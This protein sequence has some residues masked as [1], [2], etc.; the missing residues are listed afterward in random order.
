MNVFRSNN[1]SPPTDLLN[2]TSSLF[3]AIKYVPK[4]PVYLPL[5]YLNAILH[6]SP[7][8]KMHQFLFDAYFATGKV[9]CDVLTKYMVLDTT[10][11]MKRFTTMVIGGMLQYEIEVKQSMD[12]HKQER[13]PNQVVLQSVEALP[14]D[15]YEVL[16]IRKIEDGGHWMDWEDEL[17][18]NLAVKFSDMELG[19]DEDG[20]VFVLGYD[21][22]EGMVDREVEKQG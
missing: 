10:T 1:R 7:F 14:V 6:T 5:I 21:S 9:N 2:L 13:V 11:A 18:R 8:L 12:E 15:P 4:D 22:H 17:K 3:L 19:V 16:G 20:D